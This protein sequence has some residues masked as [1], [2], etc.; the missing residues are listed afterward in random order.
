MA[1]T[2]LGKPLNVMVSLPCADTMMSITAAC[3]A[4][5]MCESRERG[6]NLHAMLTRGS[7]IQNNRAGAA[8]NMRASGFDAL[9]FIDSDMVFPPDAL[10]RL[11]AHGDLD[12]IG[13]TYCER[14]ETRTVNGFELGGARIDV[15]AG[16][17]VREV[18]SLPTGFM[19]IRRRVL[20]T[21][22]AK[23]DQPFFRTPWDAGAQHSR[24]EDYDFCRRVRDCGFAVHVDPSL[25]L[26]MGHIGI[27]IYAI[28]SGDG[29]G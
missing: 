28:P 18:A 9:L 15:S 10:L 29:I 4:G 12:V 27:T 6:V 16:G 17:P 22:A 26:A 1:D 14:N 3:F 5:L 24:G 21:L 20:D 8:C 13:A 25:S 23:G 2:E 11:L 19:L 7:L